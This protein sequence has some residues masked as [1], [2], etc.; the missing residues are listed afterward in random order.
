MRPGIEVL[1]SEDLFNKR[2]A[3]RHFDL[4]EACDDGLSDFFIL[5]PGSR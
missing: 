2:T 1:S 5:V 3:S 4:P